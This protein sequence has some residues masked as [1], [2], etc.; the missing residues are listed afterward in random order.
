LSMPDA[1]QILEDAAAS[2]STSVYSMLNYDLNFNRDASGFVDKLN[3]G[4]VVA[5]LD[6]N[7]PDGVGS[8]HQKFSIQRLSN[9]EATLLIGSID[10]SKWGVGPD[11]HQIGLRVKGPAIRDV[12]ITFLDRWKSEYI[13]P[14]VNI[15]YPLENFTYFETDGPHSIQ[16]LRTYG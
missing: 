10:V 5:I 15:E 8:S 16:V 9:T 7:Y 1:C 13:D 2:G 3:Q 14:P 11:I 4:G 6:D 12:E